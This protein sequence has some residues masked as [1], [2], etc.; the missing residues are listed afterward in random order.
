MLYNVDMDSAHDVT[1]TAGEA[2]TAA[3]SAALALAVYRRFGRDS[4][5]AAAA[6]RRLLQNGTSDRDFMALCLDAT[7]REKME[8]T[9]PGAR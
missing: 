4:G 7:I 2:F 8:R 3:D 1:T 5:A 6:W 9:G